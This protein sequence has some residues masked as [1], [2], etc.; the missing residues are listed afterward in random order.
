[1]AIEGLVASTAPLILPR[2]HDCLPLLAGAPNFDRQERVTEKHAFFLSGGWMEGEHTL[3]TGHRRSV[4]R[5]GETK[6]RELLLRT[7]DAYQKFVF[8]RTQH[9]R[10]AAAISDARRLS[11]LTELPLEVREARRDFMQQFVRGTWTSELF[12]RVE[13]GQ[14]I[15]QELLFRNTGHMSSIVHTGAGEDCDRSITSHG[16]TAVHGKPVAD[17][18]VSAI[19]DSRTLY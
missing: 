5:F 13:K 19:T 18:G 8:L 2:V 14:M 15:S 3:L 1:M 16:T 10:E 7:I 4:A 9:P 11:V 12:L 6:A 17:E